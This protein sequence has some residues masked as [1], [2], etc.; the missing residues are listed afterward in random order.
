MHYQQCRVLS[1]ISLGSLGC[2]QVATST[3]STTGREA[4][5]L[6]LR[7]PS[8]RLENI[9]LEAAN[10][11]PAARLCAF[12]RLLPHRGTMG[13]FK[14]NIYLSNCSWRTEDDSRVADLLPRSGL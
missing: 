8:Q 2:F 12:L 3:R 10:A 4:R 1:P 9:R 7:R 6:Y 13:L 14:F 11:V 5:Q